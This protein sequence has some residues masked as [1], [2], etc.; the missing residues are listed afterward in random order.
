MG[1]AIVRVCGPVVCRSGVFRRR[2][3]C[4]AFE[5]WCSCERIATGVGGDEASSFEEK[6]RVRSGGAWTVKLSGHCGGQVHGFAGQS[7]HESTAVPNGRQT[8]WAATN[9]DAEESRAFIG[10]IAVLYVHIVQSMDVRDPSH[11]N[12]VFTWKMVTVTGEK[13]KS[14]NI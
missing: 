2:R 11:G 9:D 12:R 4:R 10:S 13:H 7:R 6:R 14:Q 5:F 1:A 3:T 8:S